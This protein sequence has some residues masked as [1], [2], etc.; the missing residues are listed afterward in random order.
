MDG[1]GQEKKKSN[2]DDA[3]QFVDSNVL[4]SSNDIIWDDRKKSNQE[5][6]A[7]TQQNVSNLTEQEKNRLYFF[8]D[9]KD[10]KDSDKFNHT[11]RMKKK[12][13][14][15]QKNSKQKKIKIKAF[16]KTKDPQKFSREPVKETEPK[17]KISIHPRS[18]S[19]SRPKAKLRFKKMDLSKKPTTDI[20]VPPNKNQI[21]EPK[22]KKERKAIQL[23]NI[24]TFDKKSSE[25]KT[26]SHSFHILKEKSETKKEEKAEKKQPLQLKPDKKEK[27]KKEKQ[28]KTK[29][30]QVT[31]Q[32]TSGSIEDLKN[33]LFRFKDE[34]MGTMGFSIQEEW[35]EVDFY[36]L[37]E[38]FAYIS[39]VQ[40]IE[41]R[42]KRYILLELP[43]DPVEQ[44]Q[45]NFI[46]DA[47]RT[48]SINTDEVEEE[49]IE[50]I[51]EKEVDEI[52]NDYAIDISFLSK[53]KL[54]YWLKKELLGLGKLE[55]L[56]KDVEIED[57]S[58]DGST[59]PIFLYHRRQ[60][61]IQ[62][63]IIFDD[64]E[65]LSSYVMKLA[66][67]CGKHISIANPMLDAT[68]P[69]GSRIQMT[70]STEVS[71]KG[72]TFTIRK[73][74]EQPFSPADLV[75]FNTL[76]S[77]MM[78]YLWL[79]VQHGANALIAGGT[80]S[81]KTSTL[82]AISLFIPRESKIVSIEETREI[83]L[84][85][86][87]WIPGVTRTGFGDIIDGKLTGEIDLYDLMKAAL[88][89]RPEFIIVGEIRG[90]EAYVL[91]QAMATGHT[92]YSTVHADSTKS[93]I[94]RLEGEPINIPRIMLQS[95]DIVCIQTIARVKNKRARRVKQIIEIIDID[96]TTKEILTNE[97]FKWDP[98]E[99]TYRYSGKSYLLD[100]I[101]QKT[102]LSHE[103]II[104]EL[105]QRASLLGW[106][107]QKKIHSFDDV[108]SLTANY[109]ENPDE[110]MNKLKE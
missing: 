3:I 85:H 82:N 11:I 80:A 56:M 33:E 12:K 108:A 23:K 94:H 81:G 67:K 19:A 61:S 41:N 51:F 86:P 35:N 31:Q 92:T 73:F 37:I 72:S 110:V 6:N 63:N 107:V 45:Y 65:E 57:I 9:G 4:D 99:D 60:G 71:T 91:F 69:D 89:Q 27:P 1:R 24:I 16:S 14:R 22:E 84:P 52:I 83:N 106:M 78:A 43:L 87:N 90:K 105:K 96:P 15:E 101:R 64:E 46:I 59:V 74:K 7:S 55:P 30:K 97:V 58:C 36:P 50:P 75:E 76:S 98:V 49:G 34:V 25:S 26:S 100:Q 10:K 79:A 95:L 66:Q 29:A 40:N 44:D 68:M 17:G 5:H 38:P 32:M 103:D 62:S 18:K 88:R 70:L 104:A 53:H 8:K 48:F 39:I 54:M 77:D 13:E 102:N 28:K 21:K 47:L 93:L 109:Y 2:H 20:G 42:E